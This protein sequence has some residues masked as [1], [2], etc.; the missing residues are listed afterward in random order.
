M[1]SS[2]PPIESSDWQLRSTMLGDG[3]IIQN[4]NGWKALVSHAHRTED[5]VAL[6]FVGVLLL[7]ALCAAL[8]TATIVLWVRM[9]RIVRT[10]SDSPR[11]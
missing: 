4:P 3:F 11:P 9:S 6:L 2:L 8:A 7:V 10:T 5:Q 1:Q